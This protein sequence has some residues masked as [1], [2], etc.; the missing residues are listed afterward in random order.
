MDK[1]DRS[2]SYK[3]CQ[4]PCI[5]CGRQNFLFCVREPYSAAIRFICEFCLDDISYN[6]RTGYF[7]NGYGFFDFWP[8]SDVYKQWRDGKTYYSPKNDN[9]GEK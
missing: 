8:R 4:W 6:E 5:K 1:R 2:F 7:L 3:T 9:I